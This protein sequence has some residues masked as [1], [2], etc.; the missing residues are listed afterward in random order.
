MAR[1][2]LVVSG[3]TTSWAPATAVTRTSEP[4]PQTDA[5]VAEKLR[6]A[7]MATT[8]TSPMPR[9][10]D[11]HLDPA[12]R[13]DHVLELELGT[14]L[15]PPEGAEQQANRD[16]ADRAGHDPDDGR[17]GAAHA[18]DLACE[19]ASGP[20]QRDE[21]E[22]RRHDPAA[23]HVVVDADDI[24]EPAEE[25]AEDDR[26]EEQAAADEQAEQEDRVADIDLDH[27]HP[28]ACR[29][30]KHCGSRGGTSRTRRCGLQDPFSDLAAGAYLRTPYT[31]V[32]RTS[33]M[34][35]Y[36]SPP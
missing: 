9:R 17:R 15:G 26:D 4:G 10:P 1:T 7:P 28:P 22:D 19:Q 12:G 24:G 23:A 27:E 20:E 13:A 14:R 6:G 16:G 3:S 29:T 21:G 34:S 33:R 32:N 11:A 30:S 25:L 8:S 5:D 2:V 18:Q 36:L 31:T 35:R